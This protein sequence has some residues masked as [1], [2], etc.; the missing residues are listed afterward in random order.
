MPLVLETNPTSLA[1]IPIVTAGFTCPPLKGPLKMIATNSD[2][3][4]KM[5]GMFAY[6]LLLTP[7][8]SSAIP[9]ASNIMIVL[10]GGVGI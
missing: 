2:V 6:T 4:T 9:I 5:S 7:K 1:Q 10:A 8:V 3:A